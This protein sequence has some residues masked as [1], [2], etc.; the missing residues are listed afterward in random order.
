[1]K[2]YLQDSV[3][4]MRNGRYC[5]PV[6][7]EHRS[8]V[9]GMIHD[10]SGSGSTVFIEPQAVVQLN[11]QIKELELAE[12]AEIQVILASLSASA[13]EVSEPLLINYRLL[14]EMDRG[15]LSFQGTRFLG[16][17]RT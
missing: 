7:Q 1:M 6:R 2:T 9:P 12:K 16:F 4:T 11:N 13:S 5:I 14:V 3:V 8:H 15:R 17:E 10:Q